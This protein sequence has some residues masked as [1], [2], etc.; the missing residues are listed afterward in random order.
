M[1]RRAMGSEREDKQTY[2][3]SFATQD[4]VQKMTYIEVPTM[5]SPY[6][7]IESVLK[8]EYGD[9]LAEIADYDLMEGDN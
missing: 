2:W 3:V 1:N 5:Y 9:D 6:E 8:D 4:G 7:Y